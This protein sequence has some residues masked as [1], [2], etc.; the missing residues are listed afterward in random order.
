MEDFVHLVAPVARLAAVPL[1]GYAVVRLARRWPWATLALLVALLALAAGAL[2]YA[3]LDGYAVDVN[4]RRMTFGSEVGRW[5]FAIGGIGVTLGLPA[6]LL[7]PFA[8]ARNGTA[9]GP[10]G[11]G[12]WFVVL[13]GYFMACAICGAVLYSLLT[14]IIK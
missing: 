3:G 10:V 2:A 7:V 5:C 6:L 14:G 13:F 8:R 1:I 9:T 4:T 11:G 12:Q